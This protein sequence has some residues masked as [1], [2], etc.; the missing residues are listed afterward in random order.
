VLTIP[1]HPSLEFGSA[2]FTIE[3]WIYRVGASGFI[4]G[5]G[6]AA[7]AAGSSFALAFNVGGP[8]SF[9]F[10]STSSVGVD[11][12]DDLSADQW[13]HVAFVRTAGDIVLYIDGLEVSR[14]TIGSGVINDTA[15]P[16]KIGNYVGGSLECFI[17]ELRIIKG[18]AAYTANFTPSTQPFAD[19]PP[20][21]PSLLLH[22]DGPSAVTDSSPNALTF[23]TPPGSFNTTTKKFG[24]ASYSVDSLQGLATTTRGIPSLVGVNWTVEAWVY[25]LSG[26][27]TYACVVSLNG[28]ADNSE[29]AGGLHLGVN[30][31]GSGYCNDGG[32]AAASSSAGA[33]PVGQWVHIAAVRSGGTTTL[34]FNGVADGT[35]SQEVVAGPY[36]ANVGAVPG[37]PYSAFSSDILIDEL[38]IIKGYAAY[39][40]NFTPPTAPHGS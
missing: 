29:F 20:P 1:D 32:S 12:M 35:T 9:Y 16:L 28:A 40:T 7:T 10:D 23:T 18:Y 31:N 26:D 37:A 25:R 34:Y 33:V 19:P 5:K 13:Q 15:Q 21:L 22:M 6:D 27:A 24:N 3:F 4:A 38:R 2:D 30:A 14:E 39:T 11:G 8:S 36:F 17:D